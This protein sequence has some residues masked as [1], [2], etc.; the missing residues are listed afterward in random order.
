M[1]TDAKVNDGGMRKRLNRFRKKGMVVIRMSFIS[2]LSFLFL[3]P[4]KN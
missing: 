3:K 1:E 2:I 4:S